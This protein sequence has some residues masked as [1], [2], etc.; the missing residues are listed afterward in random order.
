MSTPA[1]GG[2]AF[3][4]EGNTPAHSKHV[5]SQSGMS[6]RDWFAGQA[7]HQEVDAIIGQTVREA[8]QFLGIAETEYKC[9][10]HYPKACGKARYQWADAMLAARATGKPKQ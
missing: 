10:I 2:P 4:R 1:D 7:P 3:P 5:C 6:L 8:S 9:E